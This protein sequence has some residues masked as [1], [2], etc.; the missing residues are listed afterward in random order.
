MY[1]RHFPFAKCLILRKRREY[2]FVPYRAS[3]LVSSLRNLVYVRIFER[4]SLYYVS[5]RQL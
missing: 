2:Y 3:F 5:K 1:Q 4:V